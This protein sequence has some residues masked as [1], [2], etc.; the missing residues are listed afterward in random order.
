MTTTTTVT[1]CA[2]CV[3]PMRPN[4]TPLND[5]PGTV[6]HRAKGLCDTCYITALQRKHESQ[7]NYDPLPFPVLRRLRQTHPPSADYI[8]ERRTRGIPPE[9]LRAT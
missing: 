3:R 1:K 5:H 7:S 8:V 6:M 2:Q 4:K 9:G